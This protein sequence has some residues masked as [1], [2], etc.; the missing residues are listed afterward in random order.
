[1]RSPA[2]RLA[3]RRW[4]SDQY[5]ATTD[6]LDHN[7]EQGRSD[8]VAVRTPEGEWTY[9]QVAASAN[10]IGNALG[11]LGLEAENRVLMAV[12]DSSEFAATFFGAIKLGAVPVPVNTNLADTDYAYLLE[13]SRAKIA[14]VSEPLADAFRRARRQ[15]SYPR[16]L[17]VIGE[18]GPGELSLAEI[19]QTA[20]ADL[21]PANTTRDDVGFWLYSSGATGQPKGVVH[22]QHAMRS[23]F[24]AYAKPVLG[25]DESDVTFSV[26]KLYFA[27]G[28]GNSLYFPFAAGATNVLVAEPALP[29]LIFEV[30]RR[31]RP[32]IYFGVPTSYAHVL[33]ASESSWKAADF[34]SVRACVSA[35]ERLPASVLRRW[36][37]KTGLDILDGL[38]STESCHIFISNRQGDVRPDCSGTVVDGYEARVVD[39]EQR[40]VP[41]G[42]AGVL[43]VKGG[44]S[45]RPTGGGR[46]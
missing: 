2:Q 28:L 34:G 7:L 17:V 19:T 6:L 18:A 44:P 11:E 22:L 27:Y 3:H 12:Q 26:S 13:D 14:V 21:S 20:A 16:H 37:E 42:Q 9:A 45:A 30:V 43:L 46:G 38:G 29:R 40:V 4:S 33:G 1:M 32:T 24:E 36:K 35:S 8:K 31:F 41:A 23:C 39:E 25:L 15:T 5:N 10:R